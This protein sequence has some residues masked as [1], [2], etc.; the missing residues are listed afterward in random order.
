M[1]RRRKKRLVQVFVAQLAV[2]ALDESVLRWL[3]GGRIMPFHPSLLQPAQD[4]HAGQL[5]SV[6]ADCHVQLALAGR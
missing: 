5:G 3:A 4:R 1:A 6:V 2:E